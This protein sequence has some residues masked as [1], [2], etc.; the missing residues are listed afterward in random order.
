MDNDIYINAQNDNV[1]SYSAALD[2]IRMGRKRSCWIWYVFPILKEEELMADFYSRYFAFEIV[3]DAKAYAADSIL[4]ERLVTIT[5][6]LLAHD[7]PISEL[8]ASDI[9]VKKLHA[10][11]T[12]FG[13]ICPDKKC[14]ELVLEKFYDGKPRSSTVKLINE[15]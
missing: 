12:L 13:N 10:C 14:F 15:L 7:K 2:E 5:D 3:D 11:M 4:L 6:A 9:D 1:N 8:M